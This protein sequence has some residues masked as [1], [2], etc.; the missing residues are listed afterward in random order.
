MTRY[1]EGLVQLIGLI[2]NHHHRHTDKKFPGVDIVAHSMGGLVVREALRKL[3]TV[4]KGS[5][6]EL[7]HRIVTLGTPHRGIAFQRIPGWALQHLPGTKEAVDE[8]DA[9]DPGGKDFLAIADGFPIERILTVVGTNYRTYGAA[10]ASLANRLASLFD[11]GSLQY[12]RSDGLVKQASA[13]LP[14]APGL[15]STNAMVARTRW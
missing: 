5:V 11:E 8:L 1:G 6:G 7:I 13:Q 9:F 10:A 14:G 12:N 3:D 15:S 2:Q 4:D